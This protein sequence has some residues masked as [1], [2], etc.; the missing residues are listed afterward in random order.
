[1]ADTVV[2]LSERDASLLRGV[3]DRIRRDPPEKTAGLL[4]AITPDSDYLPPEKYLGKT[5][6]GGI[7]GINGSVL[8][9]AECDVYRC[10]DG[11]ATEATGS[12]K[13][14]Y[15]SGP[16]VEGRKFVSIER[17]KYG[18]WHVGT[19]GSSLA[20]ES[21]TA[22]GNV[23][24]GPVTGISV[25]DFDPGTGFQLRF[26][27]AAATVV[28]V[29][30]KAASIDN[31]GAVT[32]NLITPQEFG[33]DKWFQN[34][35]QF[36]DRVSAI[37]S[38]GPGVAYHGG[39]YAIHDAGSG[40]DV[41]VWGL[42]PTV[43][44]GGWGTTNPYNFMVLCSGGSSSPYNGTRV[45]LRVGY[46]TDT[47]TR[48]GCTLIIDPRVSGGA[49]YPLPSFNVN[50]PGNLSVIHKGLWQDVDVGDAA[51]TKLSFKGGLFVGSYTGAITTTTTNTT[52]LP[53]TTTAGATTT[54]G[55]G[56]TAGATTT[57]GVTTTA[58]GGTTAGA[59]T[60]AS[61]GTTAGATTTEAATTTAAA[62]TTQASTT[63][64]AAGPTS[65][66][67]GHVYKDSV[68]WS[69]AL[70]TAHPIS[71]GATVD[72]SGNTDANGNYTLSGLIAGD[73]Q[74]F[75]AGL[76]TGCLSDPTNRVVTISPPTNVT[77]VNFAVSCATPVISSTNPTSVPRGTSTQITIT[78]SNFL[79]VTSVKFGTT[80][81]ASFTINSATQITAMTPT[82]G[83]QGSQQLTVS[84]IKGASNG[85][86][87]S[88]L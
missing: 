39:Y 34:Q 71:G 38:P 36:Y 42:E 33:G 84:N 60:T 76:T 40:T 43:A 16:A 44:V 87:V 81:A 23:T 9:Y 61:G 32:N 25:L 67:S 49:S 85:V 1:V 88:F 77:G 45:G 26:D 31:W 83:S 63:T 56:T 70:V 69:G 79:G 6:A 47:D 66:V 54:S 55:G 21:L 58:S 52:T 59:T 24:S 29:G 62:T 65:S 68:N 5:P 3:L 18:T 53:V 19:A 17:D 75:V 73:W 14:V 20:V 15:N 22:L 48:F 8:G 28:I 13:T 80:A 46:H 74:V 30:M 4:N 7:P 78:G 64:T 10:L 86:A 11:G 12:T 27:P 35:V 82:F 37:N 41:V 72:I 50:D 2:V 51:G 57:S